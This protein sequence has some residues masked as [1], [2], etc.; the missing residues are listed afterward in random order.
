M[1]LIPIEPSPSPVLKNLD[2]ISDENLVERGTLNT[3]SSF[4][5]Y[6]SLL[7]RDLSY[8]IRD[9][10]RIHCGYVALLCGSTLFVS[11]LL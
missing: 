10:M 8:D 7:D 11:S 1:S 2:F 4:G 6:P 5:G 9:S 3:G